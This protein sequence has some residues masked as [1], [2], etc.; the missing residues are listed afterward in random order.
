M[1][2]GGSFWHRLRMRLG[3]DDAM[4]A[5]ISD[6]VQ[7]QIDANADIQEVTE[8]SI[9]NPIIISPSKMVFRDNLFS[10]V[11]R[12]VTQGL[13]AYLPLDPDLD[14]MRLWV[15]NEHGGRYLTDHSFLGNKVQLNGSDQSKLIFSTDDDLIEGSS[16]VNQLIDDQYIRIED[17][18]S[19][20][21]PNVRIKEI[22]ATAEGITVFIRLYVQR[23]E[24][25]QLFGKPGV[26]FSK[27][28]TEQVDFGY[29]AYLRTDGSVI[30]F[31]RDTGREYVVST[32][33]ATIVFTQANLPDYT[34]TDYNPS[35]YHTVATIEDLPDPIPFTDLAFTFKFSDKSMKVYKSLIDQPVAVV[36]DS[37]TNPEASGLV[38]HWRLVEGGDIGNTPDD[39]S[40]YAR[41][42]YNA[43]TTG[44]NG[45]ITNATWTAD[46]LLSFDGTG[47]SIS[48][49][50]YAAI[51]TL[52]AMTISLWYYPRTDA[53][54]TNL[55]AKGTGDSS[56]L[57]SHNT[58]DDISFNV[59]NSGST[60]QTATAD[61]VMADLNQWYH[62]VGR[63]TAGAPVK[64]NVNNGT[65]VNSSNLS[66]SVT[67]SGEALIIGDTGASAPDGLIHDVKI[68]NRGLSDSEVT[69]LYNAGHP[70]TYLPK[71]EANPPSEP[72]APGPITNPFVSVYDVDVPAAGEQDLVRLHAIT[73][74]SLTERYNVGQGE[75]Q[76]PGGVGEDGS[77]YSNDPTYDAGTTPQ[78][79][80]SNYNFTTTTTSQYMVLDVANFGGERIFTGSDII[81]K[82][83]TKVIA[84][85][86]DVNASTVQ[87]DSTVV[88]K[89][90][91]SSDNTPQATSS[92]VLASSLNDNQGGASA[93]YT[94]ATFTFTNNTYN[95]TNN[96][97]IQFEY[98]FDSG[99]GGGGGGGEPPGSILATYNHLNATIG[100]PVGICGY[101]VRIGQRWG[102]GDMVGEVVTG[103]IIKL[104]DRLYTGVQATGNITAKVC[105]GL[106]VYHTSNAIDASTLPDNSGATAGG[107]W[108]AKTF[109][110]T[111]PSHTMTL[112]DSIQIDFNFAGTADNRAIGVAATDS[113]V[114]SESTAIQQ[115]S[116]GGVTTYSSKDLCMDVYVQ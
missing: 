42:V 26:L 85:M 116:G 19:S 63:W 70:I 90:I 38:G 57:L 28:D 73:A 46:N 34:D 88:A 110:F 24:N 33:P 76:T 35:D 15:K 67:N 101:G 20:P 87:A 13:I 80:L 53:H 92:T 36:A 102:F 79:V 2:S 64:I 114:N 32:A 111:S 82:P 14:T 66:G 100:S 77:L 3:G 30:W 91:K 75:Q 58:G 89:I 104:C 51:D 52:S 12:T 11:K 96:D 41:T 99:A 9:L 17:K 78:E 45:T 31:V 60:S 22:A 7:K 105:N 6:L 65:V 107:S 56:F 44:N 95:M 103:I 93:T 27:I 68:W 40:S 62:I 23:N 59:I 4:L 49:T 74:T 39:P 98:Y 69:A 55:V 112:N 115:S 94:D 108:A 97:R 5:Q 81:G 18:D 25:E 48:V 1:S 83:I 54:T 37:S 109:I 47:D 29:G 50:G 71:W 113:S 72:P 106:T 16:I 8:E 10:V 84:K 61:N 43:V 86:A 21:N